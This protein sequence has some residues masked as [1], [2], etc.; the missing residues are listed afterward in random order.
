MAVFSKKESP[1]LKSGDLGNIKMIDTE[2]KVTEKKFTATRNPCKL[3]APLGASLVFKGVEGAI[4]LLHGSQG[5][6]TYIRR[7]LISHFKEPVDIASSSF[8][9]TTAIFG[10]D[11]NLIAA[12]ENVCRQY[13]PRLIGVATTCLS[14]TIGDDVPMI[15][16]KFKEKHKNEHLP[17]IVHVSTPSYRGTHMDGFYEAVYALVAYFSRADVGPSKATHTLALFPGFVSPADMRHLKEIV[18]NFGLPCTMLPDYS[19]TLDGALWS[20]YHKIPEG[21]TP[22]NDIASMGHCRASVE[23]GNTLQGIQ[24]AATFLEEKFDVSRHTCGLPIGINLT[25]KFFDILEQISGRKVP[26]KYTNERARLIDSYADAHKYIFNKKAIV[27][28][29]E[30]LVVSV[31]SF[32]FEIGVTPI[33]CASGSRNNAPSGT[34]RMKEALEKLETQYRR[35]ISISEGTDFADILQEAK[36]FNP[37]FLIGSSKGY[38]IA[39]QLDIPLVRIGF[40]V[41][42]RIGAAR[43]LHLGYRGTQNLFDRIVNS[44]IE[45]NQARSSVGPSYM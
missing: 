13:T 44:I 35:V 16:K 34:S 7:Y 19:Q 25:D 14:E 10:G 21:G 18:S 17:H 5:C 11:D 42:D 1:L 24:S 23:F 12:L 6:A 30:D 3:C 32:L 37:D 15:L 39:R 8:V 2:N 38:S 36:V 40:P 28:G 31:A 29:E 9:E 33:L 45:R 4:C 22:F 43:I 27:F 20:E 41:H 26:E